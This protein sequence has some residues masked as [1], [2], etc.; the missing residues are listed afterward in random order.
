ME[1]YLIK[2]A[3]FNLEKVL[4]TP[5]I[6]PHTDSFLLEEFVPDETTPCIYVADLIML[7]TYAKQQ[8]E[9]TDG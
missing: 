1:K 4:L 7:L 5:K 2:D 8:L 6:N 3:L 9:N